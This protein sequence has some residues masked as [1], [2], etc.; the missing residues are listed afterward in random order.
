MILKYK[1][2]LNIHFLISQ[3]E[4][5]YWNKVEDENLKTLLFITNKKKISNIKQLEKDFLREYIISKFPKTLKEYQLLEKFQSKRLT[6]E[7]VYKMKVNEKE[8]VVKGVYL[9]NDYVYERFEKEVM[10]SDFLIF[11]IKNSSHLCVHQIMR[12]LFV[13]FFGSKKKKVK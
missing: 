2:N 3:I 7:Y 1:K 4:N 9:N 13:I 8:V 10:Q 6:T 5:L 11:L 12:I